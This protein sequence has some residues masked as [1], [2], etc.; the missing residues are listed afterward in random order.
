MWGPLLAWLRR[1]IG[2]RTDA[3][4]ATGSLHAKVKNIADNKIGD[5]T[6][7]RADNTVMGWM[8]TQVKSW[9]RVTGTTASS[10]AALT[11]S[12]SSV[13]PA[14]CKVFV[15]GCRMGTWLTGEYTNY[16]AIPHYISAFSAASISLTPAIG[17]SNWQGGTVSVIVV[18]LY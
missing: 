10:S 7:V 3:A 6:D 17:V 18:E 1:Q 15:D 13:D 8:N 5:S 4:S 16:V 12:L 2:Q 14:K 9:Q 11:L